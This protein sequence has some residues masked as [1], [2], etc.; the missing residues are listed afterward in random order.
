MC[1]GGGHSPCVEAT[2]QGPEAASQ[3]TCEEAILEV[4][5]VWATSWLQLCEPELPR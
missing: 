2:G 5:A 1:H 3:Q 4:N